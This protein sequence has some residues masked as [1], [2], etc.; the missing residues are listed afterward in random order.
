[1][2]PT[3]DFMDKDLMFIK[4]YRGEISY[5]DIMFKDT[6]VMVGRIGLESKGFVQTN[7]ANFISSD[8]LIQIATFIEGLKNS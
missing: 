6:P 3:T 4:C 8:H 1:M 5:Y 2:I 7:I